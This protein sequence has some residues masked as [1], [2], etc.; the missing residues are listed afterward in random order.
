MSL[1][2]F[3]L[4][5]HTAPVALRERIAFPSEHLHEA[6]GALRTV[7]HVNEAVIL[8]TCNRTELYCALDAPDSAELGG[9]LMNYHHLAR[10]TLAPYL[11]QHP[12][13]QAVRHTLRVAAGLDSMIVGEPQILGQMK[14]AYAAARAAG[15][16]GPLLGRL[17]EHSFAVAKQIRTDTAIGSSPVS[18]AFAAVSLARQIFADLPRHTALLIGAGSTIE[19]CARHL[20]EQGIGRMIIANRSLERAHALAA[21]FNGYAIALAEMPAHLAEADIV[22]SSTAS[23]LPVLGKGSVERALAQ[24]KRHPMFMVDLAVPRDIEPE[25][26][27]LD[28][29]YLYTVDDL[30]DVIEENLRTRR[31]AARQAEEIIDVQVA[32]F[33]GWLRSLDAVATIRALRDTSD[34][35]QGEALAKARRLI[36]QGRSPEEAMQLLAHTLANRL[37]HAPTARLRQAG[38]EG[39]AALLAAARTLFGLD[40]DET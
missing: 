20:N 26:A 34:A 22:I 12:G 10:D 1:L 39:D 40:G 3:G 19:L 5:H 4:N 35:A 17:F 7:S 32:E 31:E 38:G 8:S 15:S 28:D 36:A 18:V 25:V 6:L 29:V 37:I 33:M 24:R 30:K 14:Q 23:P 16:V 27:A 9:W 13:P 2:A 11:F 21:Q